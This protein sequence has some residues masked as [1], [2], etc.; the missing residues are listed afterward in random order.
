MYW[1]CQ[2]LTSSHRIQRNRNIRLTVPITN[3]ASETSCQYGAESAFLLLHCY[4]QWIKQRVITHRFICSHISTVES[5]YT[6]PSKATEPVE[7][8]K[9]SGVCI[10][11]SCVTV[12]LFA[13]VFPMMPVPYHPSA[14]AAAEVSHP[15]HQLLVN[16]TRQ[17][18]YHTETM[19]MV[20]DSAARRPLVV[21]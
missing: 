11:Y 4:R 16:A 2:N 15:N 18:K 6:A 12:S 7:A 8:V 10:R 20:W 19:M 3:A 5:R 14:D 1:I 9:E 21:I 17:T 13:V